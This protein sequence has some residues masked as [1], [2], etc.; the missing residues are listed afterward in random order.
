MLWPL[1]VTSL[2]DLSPPTDQCPADIAFVLDASGSVTAD[3]FDKM[4]SFVSNFGLSHDFGP[5][6]VQIALVSFGNKA[7]AHI[8]L[9]Q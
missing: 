3:N 2:C 9:N 1:S 7:T 4:L 6:A 8:K 5:Q